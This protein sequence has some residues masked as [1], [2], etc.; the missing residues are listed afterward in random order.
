MHPAFRFGI[1]AAIVLLFFGVF[2]F[3][4]GVAP[5]DYEGRVVLDEQAPGTYELELYHYFEHEYN[6]YAENGKVV[7]VEVLSNDEF[8][9]SYQTCEE[10]QECHVIEENAPMDGFRCIG[11][12]YGGEGEVGTYSIRFSV[13]EGESATV[14]VREIDVD[15]GGLMGILGPLSIVVMFFALPSI[16]FW[17]NRKSSSHI[18]GQRTEFSTLYNKTDTME[19]RFVKVRWSDNYDSRITWDEGKLKVAVGGNSSHSVTVGML[20]GSLV[21]MAYVYNG[22]TTANWPMAGMAAFV[23][24]VLFIL[25]LSKLRGQEFMTV[26]ENHVEILYERMNYQTPESHINTPLSDINEIT[27]YTRR[28]ETTDS[29]GDTSYHNIHLTGIMLG[30]S[31]DDLSVTQPDDRMPL[32]E[33]E[34]ATPSEAENLADSLNYLLQIKE[35]EEEESESESES[36]K[37]FWD[38]QD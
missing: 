36:K 21:A 3:D 5:T 28:V 4:I 10:Y 29:D 8:G 7:S 17:Q 11:K 34:S 9:A 16:L 24:I 6:V 12:L 38:Q 18:D 31:Y 19:E 35:Y 20:L 32:V 27:H 30:N 37:N 15:D 22:A 23:F 25:F 14:V 2:M 26:H 1:P 13:A 33:I